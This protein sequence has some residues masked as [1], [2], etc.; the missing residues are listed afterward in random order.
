LQLSGLSQGYVSAYIYYD[1]NNNGVIDNGEQLYSNY[2]SV[3]GTAQINATLGASGNY[4]V[5]IVPSQNVNSNYSLQLAATAAPPSLA[6]DP[7]NTPSTAY[8]IGNLTTTQT[9]KEF[10][11][12]TDPVDYYKFSLTSTSDVSLQLGGLSQGYVSAYIYYDANNN[13]LIDNGEQLYSTYA[14]VG[15]TAQ[16]A[17]TLQAGNYYV[18]IIPNQNVNSNYSLSLVNATNSTSGTTVSLAVN[19]ASIPENGTGSLVYTFTRTGSTA[20]PLT[21]SYGVAGTAVFNTDYTQTGATTFTGT[22]GTV[23][24][25]AGSATATVAIQPIADTVTEPNEIVSL[26]LTSGTSYA[27]GTSTPVTGTIIDAST[28]VPGTLAFSSAQFSVRADGTPVAAVTISRKGGSTGAVSA[29]LNLRDGTAQ[30]P[31]DYS[32]API[33]VSFADGETSKTVTV[34]VVRETGQPDKTLQLSL[35]TP[36]GG[37][38]IAQQNSATLTILG[39]GTPIISFPQGASGSNQGQVT[40]AITGQNF[41][42][43]DQISLVAPNGTARTASKTYSVNGNQTWAT[44]DLQGLSAGKYDIKVANGSNGTTAP[45]AFTVTSGPVGNVQTQL[46]YPAPG[47]VTVTYTNIGQTDVAAPILQVFGSN[48]LPKFLY[49]PELV[50]VGSE[51]GTG[52]SDAGTGQL[53]YQG[54]GRSNTGPAGI[55]APGESGQ[56]SFNYTPSGN[57]AINYTV[58]QAN[59]GDGIDWASQ[60]AQFYANFSNYLSPTAW[61]LIWNNFTNAVG[62][63][64]GSLQAVLDRDATYLSQTGDRN[65]NFSSLLAFELE[66]AGNSLAND[67]IAAARDA[68]EATPGLSLS[69]TRTFYNGL[70]DRYQ[71]GSL[72]LGWSSNWDLSLSVDAQGNVT[73]FENGAQRFFTK[74][75]DGSYA[76]LPGDYGK[77]TL[78]SN[79]YTLQ[80]T[81][82]TLL[83]FRAVNQPIAY[84][85]QSPGNTSTTYALDYVQDPNGNRITANYTGN[86]LTSLV[87]S[88]GERLTLSYNSQGDISQ[89][90]DSTGKT[91][92]YRYDASGQHLLS[93]TTPQGTTSYTYDTTSGGAKQNTLLS[94]TNPDNTHTYFTYD[95]QGRLASQSQDGGAQAITYTYDP[96]GAVQ[97]RDALGNAVSASPN[98]IGQANQTK[99]ALGSTVQTSY[100][101]NHNLTSLTAPGGIASTYSYD[102]QGNVVRSVDPLGNS[103]SFTYT[104]TF[105]ELQTLT[106]QRGNVT[107]YNYDARGNLTGITYADGSSERYTINAQG[108]VTQSVNRSGN[109][110]NSTYNSQGRLTSQTY[111]STANNLSYTYDAHGNLTTATDANGTTTLTYDAADRLTKVTYANGRSLTY[112]YDAGG[113]R[114]SVTDQTGFTTKYLYDAV[115]R[116]TGLTDGT[117]HAIATYTYDAAGR[118]SKQVDGNGNYTTY[119]YDAAG[120]VTSLINYKANNAV[121]SSFAYTYNNL[122]QRTSQTTLDGTWTYTYD[123]TGQLTNAVFA[124][125]NTAIANQNLTYVY[126]AAGNRIKT[127]QNGTTTN[128]NAN[129]LNEYTS[130]GNTIYS[131]DRAGNLIAKVSNGQTTTYGYDANNRLIAV[132]GPDGTWTYQYDALGNRIASTHNG[133][134]TQYLIDPTTGHVIGQYDGSGQLTADYTYGFGLNSQVIGGNANYYDFDALGSTVGLAG[135]NGSYLDRYSYDPFGNSLSTTGS[136]NNPFQY[137]GQYGVINSGNGLYLMGARE[138]DP[139]TGRFT[140]TDP[141]GLNGGDSNLYNYVFNSPV[142]LNDPFGLM[143]PCPPTFPT[144]LGNTWLPYNRPFFGIPGFLTTNSQTYHPNQQG[145]V[146]NRIPSYSEIFTGDWQQ[147]CFYDDSTTN[148][149]VPGAGTPNAFDAAHSPLEHSILDPGGLPHV[150]PWLYFL[151]PL[152]VGLVRYSPPARFLYVA[153]KVI[154]FIWGDTHITTLDNTHYDFQGVGE[155]TTLKSTTDDFEIQVR[156]QPW[157]GSTKVTVATAIAL[158]IDGQ[159]IGFYLNDLDSV[160]V[161]GIAT[162]IANGTLYA[163]GQ[164]LITRNGG[165]YDIFTANGDQIQVSFA[166]SYMN[167][168]LGLSDNRKGNVIGLLGNDNGNPNDDFALRNG[169]VIGGTITNQQ[170]YGDYANS[171]RITQPT[172]LFDYA[173]GQTTNTFTDLTFPNTIV[174]STTLTPAQ[175]AAALQTARAAGITDPTLLEDAILD[176]AQTNGAPE[177]IQGY[178]T[179]QRQ[180]TL[181]APNTLINPDGF[182]SAHWLAANALIPETIRFT[183]NAAQ[184][185]T[186]IAQVTIT[187]QLDADLDLNT[188]SLSTISFGTITLT[189]PTGTKNYNQRLDLRSTR[190]VYVDVNAGL[191][192]TTGVVTWTFTAIDPTTG[193]PANSASKGFLPPNDSTGAGQGFVGYTIQPKANATTGT[194]IDDRASITFNN[195]TPIQTDPVFNTLDSDLPTSTITVVPTISVSNFT[196]AWSGNDIGS[197]LDFYDIF[198]ATDGGPFVPWQTKTTDTSALYT[199]QIGHTYAFYSVARDNVGNVEAT[200]AAPDAQIRVG[201]GNAG[202]LA[203]SLAEFRVNEDGTPITAVTINRTN[204][205]DGAVSTVLNLSDGSAIAP[206]DY[207]KTPITV[208]FADGETTKTVVIPIVNDTLYETNE[209]LNLTLSNPT[210]G[211]AIGAQNTATLAIVNDDALAVI[212]PL[213]NLSTAEDAVFSFTIPSNTFNAASTVTLTP[214]ATLSNG[215]PLPAW[216]SFN[217]TTRTFNG[218]PANEN[219]GTLSIRVTVTDGTASSTSSLF[220][221]TVTNTNDAPIVANPLAAQTAA[222]NTPFNFTVPANTF[223]DIDVGDTLTYAAT[224]NN[225][226]P[227]PTWLS[228]NPATRTF[229]GTPPISAG[230]INITVTATDT[231]GASASNTFGLAL[232]SAAPVLDLNGTAPGTSFATTFTEDRGAIAAVSMGLTLTDADSTTVTSATITISNL[233]DGNAESLAVLNTFGYMAAAYNSATG[234]LQL[235]G[236]AT[237]AQYQQVLRTIRYNNTSQNPTPTPRT[238]NFVVNDGSTNSAVVASTVSVV[239]V[240]DA[241]VLDLNGSTAGINFSTTFTEDSGF[242]AI[243][244]SRLSLSD[245]DN[246][247]MNSATVRI[248]SLSDPG[249]EFLTANTT[250]TNITA[251]YDASTGLLELRGADAIANYQQVLR[252]VAYNNTSQSPNTTARLIDFGVNDGAANSAIATTI[253]YVIAINDLPVVELTGNPVTYTENDSA[254][255]VDGGIRLSDA[256]HP[257]LQRATVRISNFVLGQD[258]LSFTPRGSITGSFSSGVLTLTGNAS[259]EDYQTVLR[260]VTYRNSSDRPTTTPRTIEFVI[261]DGLSNSLVTR[262][263]VDIAAVNDAPLLRASGVR[264]LTAIQEDPTTNPGTLV[265][266]LLNNMSSDL[267]AGALQGIAVINSTGAGTWHYSTDSGSSWSSFNSI[268]ETSALLLNPTTQV[269]FSPELNFN[270]IV[271][272]S[273]RAWDQTSGSAGNQVDTSSNGG[274]TAFSSAIA[275]SSLTVNPVNDAPVNAVPGAQALD[276]DTFLIF[277]SATGNPITISDVDAGNSPVA[278]NLTISN[279]TLQLGS[280]TG[281]TSITGNGTTHVTAT[282]TLSSLNDA[283]NGLQFTPTANFNGTTNLTLTTND[284]GNSGSGGARTDSDLISITV[285][286]VNDAP[287][288]SLPTRAQTVRQGSSLVFSAAT[289]NRLSISDVDAGT[290]IEQI[291]LSITSGTLALASTDGL[292]LLAGNNTNNLSIQGTLSTL[293]TVLN[294][295]RFTPDL[296]SVATGATTL[297]INTNDLGST[298]SGTAKTDTDSLT[299]TVTPANSITGTSGNDSLNGS[300]ANNFIQGL[301]GNDTIYGNGGDDILFGGE[302]NDVIYS[303]AGNDL[304]DGGPG[305]DTIWLGGGQ[306]IVV[307][308]RGNG[309]DTIYNYAV[310]STRFK[311]DA[312]LAFSNLGIVQ[313]GSNTLIRTAS[314]EQL[315]SLMGTQ[316]SSITTSSFI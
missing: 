100:D 114:T 161:N 18:G 276:E 306:D 94:I 273:Y 269:R 150:H 45:A 285:N 279:G 103:L 313:S 101:S 43:T 196:V 246:T 37:A 290:G 193:N 27:V 237:L 203:F 229:S 8:N 63:T 83:S 167:L 2:T 277:S 176:I 50:L 191:N 98:L 186:P 108:Q 257:T 7:G 149:L 34:P 49:G 81:D 1:A 112:T 283:L 38:T 55:L 89:I 219:V 240:N 263:T 171:W 11:G 99:D 86:K 22:T 204:G 242:T 208:D 74:Q 107:R 124:S 79:K 28:L 235:T 122:G 180:V 258:T 51:Q 66:K 187:Q 207:A 36:T 153:Y 127:I 169:T 301:A 144:D 225:G 159:R 46:S 212:N 62:N 29:T 284:L 139:I 210:G 125:T 23:T 42:P 221:L 199:G 243:V 181:S 60:K 85:I 142:I 179:Q 10:V 289:G 148:L 110:I 168:G 156:Q 310:G 305:N 25:A 189:I 266:T 296:F 302:G 54:L 249:A 13:G 135:A 234:T 133:Q 192:P 250:G 241:P 282:G 97:A 102:S 288:N 65:F 260:S 4:F 220:N 151:A 308:N 104:P 163:L 58:Q 121:N 188:F 307:L 113:R 291:N 21:V 117:N 303:A 236:A 105:N 183:N 245:V 90:T 92:S 265:S 155:F 232:L 274:I 6:S 40:I 56:F 31:S 218:T 256:D 227:L 123:A 17:K 80:E 77:L 120:E 157:G 75:S 126:D 272:L 48:A 115:G 47:V 312:G 138:Y 106:D 152:I 211:V 70:F 73:V 71:Q 267:D 178:V 129:N 146:E 294:G 3:G 68:F 254:V 82:G 239:P 233:L 287:I 96:T 195:Q 136:V 44:F 72:G 118:L 275:T 230:N 215:D 20:N 9:F 26:T 177:F 15:G 304:I 137:V 131:Y 12:N 109:Q 164:T 300:S 271:N 216:L 314:G 19:P 248:R 222:K 16:I 93:V 39:S 184:G 41:S 130:A 261:N 143:P 224:L 226:A 53:L 59:P 95:A 264:S 281:L 24:F 111:S 238:I 147:E 140:Q 160:K 78:A 295:L 132:T 33:T 270:G 209:T 185:T 14:G 67:A 154:Q 252:T 84:I 253:A 64:Y 316:A 280:L 87:Q 175:R 201:S 244:S 52:T 61:D 299:I 30:S 141:I 190:S 197:G 116:L 57:G 309:S 298:G 251:T 158:K 198:V 76:G 205:S 202:I 293:N 35:T 255:L 286:P 173:A 5:G 315:A 134:T 200:P 297:T 145:I 217:P 166:G 174:T 32:N 223:S 268:S 91:T 119:T 194:R 228:F 292:T 162:T 88:N 213:P 172:S 262:S 278:I 247:R 311:L 182:G 170:L 206:D 69:F 128:Y 259:L 165:T 231:A 214:T